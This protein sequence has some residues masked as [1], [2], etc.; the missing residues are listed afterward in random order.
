MTQVVEIDL[1][2]DKFGLAMSAA[3]ELDPGSAVVAAGAA[4]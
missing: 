2:A 1:D 4:S 3:S